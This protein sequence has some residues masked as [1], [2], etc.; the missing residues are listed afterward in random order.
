MSK[1]ED[2]SL[3]FR[4]INIARNDYD[5]NDQYNVGHPDALSTG[6]EEGKGE[7]NGK[8]GGL[9]DIKSRD[10]AITKNKYNKNK[11][12]NASTA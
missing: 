12:Y 10:I 6:D 4:N 11:E 7:M 2:V 3:S 9:T 1:L 5:N 8:I